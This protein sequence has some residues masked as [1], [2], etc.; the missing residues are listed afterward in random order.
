MANQIEI[1]SNRSVA[2]RISVDAPIM[3]NVSNIGIE[4][5]RLI[6]PCNF[7]CSDILHQHKYCVGEQFRTIEF[8]PMHRNIEI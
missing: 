1:T 7:L 3:S 4:T 5:K 6:D 8:D 2:N